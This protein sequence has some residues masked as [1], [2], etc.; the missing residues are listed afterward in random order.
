[1]GIGRGRLFG[2]KKEDI[3]DD[4]GYL[5]IEEPKDITSKFAELVEKLKPCTLKVHIYYGFGTSV[6]DKLGPETRFPTL[7][8][9]LTQ[10]L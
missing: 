3:Y 4:H 7:K 1:M 8:P 9:I 2:G 5:A 10:Y 6:K